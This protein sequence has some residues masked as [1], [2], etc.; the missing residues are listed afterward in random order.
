VGEIANALSNLTIHPG[1][2]LFIAVEQDMLR[3]WD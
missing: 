3:G 2:P 1:E